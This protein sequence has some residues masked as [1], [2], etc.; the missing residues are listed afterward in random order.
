M[1]IFI[2]QAFG[3]QWKEV[4]GSAPAKKGKG[5]K[6]KKGKGKDSKDGEGEP[7]SSQADGDK[8]N[9]EVKVDVG[10][11][12]GAGG[13]DQAKFNKRIALVALVIVLAV[14]GVAVFCLGGK[15]TPE[16]PKKADKKKNKSRDNENHKAITT[17][18]LDHDIMRSHRT[19]DKIA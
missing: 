1:Q 16:K 6:G 13:P 19:M 11:A 3:T 10:D 8:S 9:D 2:D 14:I 18:A 12:D 7:S 5:K 15:K 4:S 17:L